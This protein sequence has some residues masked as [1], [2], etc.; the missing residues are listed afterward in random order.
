VAL[1]QTPLGSGQRSPDPLAGFGEGEGKRD[2][3]E[4]KR[5]GKEKKER[6]REGGRGKG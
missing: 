1:P 2:G 5:R 3:R 6:G 4:G